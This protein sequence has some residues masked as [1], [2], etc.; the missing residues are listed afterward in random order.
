MISISEETCHG[1][2][3]PLVPDVTLSPTLDF[4]LRT[5][6]AAGAAVI[7]GPANPAFLSVPI[8]SDKGINKLELKEKRVTGTTR[9]YRNTLTKNE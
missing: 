7:T 1:D 4:F 2:C 9:I 8:S 6:S 3:C 5:P